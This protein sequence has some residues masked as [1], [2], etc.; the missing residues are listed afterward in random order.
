MLVHV[1]G[2]WVGA[3]VTTGNIVPDCP[4][5]R[6]KPDVKGIKKHPVR[7]VRIDRHA[8]VVPVLRII[9]STITEQTALR[10]LHV[11]PARAAVCGSP[12]TELT[13]GSAAA[14]TITIRG[15]RLALRIDVIR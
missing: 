4:R 12:S 9:H 3:G 13:P 8:L 14:T 6:C 7:I 1:H 11:S 15:D 5:S 10:A 2:T